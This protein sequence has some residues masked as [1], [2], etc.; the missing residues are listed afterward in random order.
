MIQEFF[1]KHLQNNQAYNL[2][3]YC[4]DLFV[5]KCKWIKAK[6]E[7]S[8]LMLPE[9][10]MKSSMV[11][12]LWTFILKRFLLSG[13]IDVQWDLEVVSLVWGFFFLYW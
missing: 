7:Q 13:C 5:S 1:H 9:Q 6:L 3:S 8:I 11:G 4:K 10:E 2:S 12:H